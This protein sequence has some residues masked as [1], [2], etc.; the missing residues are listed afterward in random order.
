MYLFILFKVLNY[1]SEVDFKVFC[2]ASAVLEQ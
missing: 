1:T 2:Y